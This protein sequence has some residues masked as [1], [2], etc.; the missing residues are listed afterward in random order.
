M[1]VCGSRKSRLEVIPCSP[2][3]RAR[4]YGLQID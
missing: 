4:S 2:M 3:K 1:A